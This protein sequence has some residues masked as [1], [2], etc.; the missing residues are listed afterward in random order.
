MFDNS[1]EAVIGETTFGKKA[2]DVGIPFQGSAEGVQDTNETGDKVPAFIH[3]MEH[4]ENDAAN[5]LKKAV[6]AGTVIQKERAKVFIY[7]KDEMPVG[8]V[9]ELKGDFSRAVNTVLVAA[10]RAK[11]RMTAERNKFKFAAVGTAVHGTAVG[12]VSTVNHLFH[13][14][15]NN[16]AWMKSIFN[17]FVMFSKNLLKDAHKS[18]MKELGRKN[19]PTPQD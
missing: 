19:N 10:G 14:F 4:S 15:H 7:G 1:P 8:T 12:G 13:V 16:G 6:K 2:M 5:R 9:N 11:F 17:F 18:I 3:F